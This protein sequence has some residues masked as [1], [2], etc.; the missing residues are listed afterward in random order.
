MVG[1]MDRREIAAHCWSPVLIRKRDR[2]FRALRAALAFCLYEAGVL[3]YQYLY[4]G[5]PESE[6]GIVL[7]CSTSP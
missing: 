4:D 6:A 7:A 2:E 1:H 5:Q 3:G